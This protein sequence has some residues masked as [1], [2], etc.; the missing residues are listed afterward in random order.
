MHYLLFADSD[1]SFH[2][3]LEGQDELHQFPDFLAA[4]HFIQR[5]KGNRSAE[6]TVFDS[7]GNVTFRNMPVESGDYLLL[8]GFRS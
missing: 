7:M 1:C 5:S 2:L 6:V 3:K 4:L 8:N